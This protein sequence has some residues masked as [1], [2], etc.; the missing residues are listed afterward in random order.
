MEY[1]SF[2]ILVVEYKMVDHFLMK[3]LSF[4]YVPS[5]IIMHMH[6]FSISSFDGHN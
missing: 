4:Q 2:V 1:I 3:L 5:L 6:I